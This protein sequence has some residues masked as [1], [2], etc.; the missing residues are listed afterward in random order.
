LGD[1]LQR[2]WLAGNRGG[3][4]LHRDLAIEPLAQIDA[5]WV[6]AGFT[7]PE[8]RNA[9]QR[10]SLAQSE[11][12]IGELRDADAVLVTVPMYNFGIPAA[13]KAWIDLV[14]RARETFAYTEQGPRGLLEDRPV[15]LVMATGGVPVGSPVDFATGYLEHVFGFIGLKDVR[16]IAADGVSLDAQAA[17]DRAKQ[18]LDV[19]LGDRAAA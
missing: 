16:V 15:Y 11:Q 17:L 19:A 12:L 6:A 3:R 10:A 14:C 4:V 7:E 8:Q 9:G 13:L 1:R 18:Q 5:D 2:R